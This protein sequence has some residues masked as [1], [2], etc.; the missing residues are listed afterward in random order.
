M[1]RFCNDQ[2]VGEFITKGK[3]QTT[4]VINFYN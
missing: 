3:L 4:V 1:G 2:G